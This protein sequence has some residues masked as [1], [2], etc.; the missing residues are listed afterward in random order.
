MSL[1]RIFDVYTQ[2]FV[3]LNPNYIVFVRKQTNGFLVAVNEGNSISSYLCPEKD[4]KTFADAVLFK[5][6]S[7]K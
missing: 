7:E 5:C 2:S 3:Y 6:G 1:I 4:W